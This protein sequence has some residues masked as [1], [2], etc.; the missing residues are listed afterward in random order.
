MIHS[1]E[2]SRGLNETCEAG[3]KGNGIDLI[4]RVTTPGCPFGLQTMHGNRSCLQLIDFISAV[5]SVFMVLFGYI[6]PGGL[7]PGEI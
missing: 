1:M 6:L 3:V 4:G 5:S 2:C 7:N